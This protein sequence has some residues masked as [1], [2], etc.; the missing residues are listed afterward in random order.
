M[1]EFFGAVDD[2]SDALDLQAARRSAVVGSV[3]P[4]SI[5]GYDETA[6]ADDEVGV[7]DGDGVAVGD[8]H[9]PDP[10]SVDECAVDTAEILEM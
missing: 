5:F 9:S 10:V 6:A 8:C 3:W 1:E 4:E 7:T 2:E